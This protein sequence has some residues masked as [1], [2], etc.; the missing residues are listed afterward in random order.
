[1]STILRTAQK[2][3]QSQRTQLRLPFK[4]GT[5]FRQVPGY[6]VFG[7]ILKRVDLEA[8]ARVMTEWLQSHADQL[9]RTLALDGKTIRDQ[10]GLIVTLV[11]AEQ[12]TPVAVA[13]NK[14]GKGH[15]L[16]T[17]QALLASPQVNLTHAIVTAD[18]LHCQ[19]QTAHIITREKGGDYLL[20]IRDNQP[21]LHQHAQTQL[22]RAAPPF[23]QDDAG[24]GRIEQRQL[25]AVATDAQAADFPEA[26]QLIKVRNDTTHKKS[27]RTE[28]ATRHFISS[29]ALKEAGA[30]RM[31]QS[32][33]G[34]WSSESAH[35]QRDACWGEDRC[36]LRSANAACALALIRTT[37]QTLVRRV[38]RRSL[39]SVFEDVSDNLALGLGW[40]KQRNLRQ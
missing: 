29:L 2:L 25:S 26:R 18:S 16:K 31:A 5:R 10:L 28:A 1:V 17:A 30:Q 24:H 7:Q 23:C 12:G 33:R 14:A 34:H 3:S 20:Q 39:P 15:E 27:G 37:L 11:D 22:A 40:L 35:W 36:R 21:T 4:K 6:D 19:D 8:L 32:I 38:G 9:P 13:A